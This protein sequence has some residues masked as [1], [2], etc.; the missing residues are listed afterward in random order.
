MSA[1]PFR[2]GEKIESDEVVF[3]CAKC[4]EEIFSDFCTLNCPLDGQHLKSG[5]AVKSTYHR[6]DVLISREV[7]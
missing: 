7:V 6:T 4:G 1:L 2:G 3:S 5:T